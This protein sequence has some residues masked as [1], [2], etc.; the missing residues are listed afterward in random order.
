VA[1]IAHRPWLPPAPRQFV[2]QIRA[3]GLHVPPL[4]AAVTLPVERRLA[5]SHRRSHRK[6]LALLLSLP[7]VPVLVA[8]VPAALLLPLF[9][10]RRAVLRPVLHR[11]LT[12]PLSRFGQG[13][14][15]Q[16]QLHRTQR[17][18]YFQG[19]LA[20]MGQRQLRRRPQQLLPLKVPL[21]DDCAMSSLTGTL[22]K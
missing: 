6:G 4:L 12:H 21:C 8:P 17:L 10:R 5:L 14:R 22:D 18:L 20:H 2:L 16:L 13:Q 11:Q 19:S 7:L 1:E 15:G 9:T 3:V